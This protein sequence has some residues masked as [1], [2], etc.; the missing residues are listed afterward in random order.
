[1]AARR[2]LLTF[3]VAGGGPTGVEM[4]GALSELIRL[5]LRKDFTRLDLGDVRIVLLE[6]APRILSG[7]PEDLSAAATLSLKGKDV[8]VLCGATVPESAGSRVTRRGGEPIPARTL[9][10]AAGVRAVGLAKALGVATAAQGRVPVEPTLQLRGHPE[11][12]VIGDAAY[13]K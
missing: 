7:M 1:A 3:V 11:V 8:A 6:A 13:L 10:W 12:F 2:A 9:I 5:V 4:A